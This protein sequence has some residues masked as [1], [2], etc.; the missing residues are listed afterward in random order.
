MGVVM[1]EVTTLPLP[2]HEWADLPPDRRQ[3][4]IERRATALKMFDSELRESVLRIIEDVRENGDDAVVRATHEFDGVELRPGELEVGEREIEKARAQV[5]DALL[6]AIRNAIDHVR[7]FNERA[8]AAREWRFEL[9]PGLVVGERVTPIVSAGLFVPSGK[10]SFPWVLVQLGTPTVVAGV[11]EVIVVVPPLPDGG[12][13]PG[14]LAVASELGLQHVFRANGPAGVAAMALGTERIPKVVK[15]VGPGSPAVATAQIECQRFGCVTNM[16]LGPSESLILADRTADLELLAADLLNEAEHGPDSAS[17]LVTWDRELVDEVQAP[18]ARRLAELPEPR[19]SYAA[20]ALRNGGAILVADAEQGAAVANLYA[21]E[22]MQVVVAE[23]GEEEL[24]GQLEHAGEVLIG[25]WTP[26]SAANYVLGI[27]AALPTGRYAR[28][29]SGITVETFVKRSSLAK[30]S[31]RT[32]A[33]LSTS[34][35]ALAE[36]EGFPAHA[37]TVRARST[38]DTDPRGQT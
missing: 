33:S 30:A 26:I 4:L 6:A 10:G 24:L 3:S 23:E 31:R 36:H 5:G 34:I 18:L 29:S 1:S 20:A 32:L 22:H 7:R 13:D 14:V 11:P 35:L 15:L 27:P 17:V 38:D 28:V 37:A 8:L 16:L 9:D 12:V 25:R 2:V 21:P 19:R